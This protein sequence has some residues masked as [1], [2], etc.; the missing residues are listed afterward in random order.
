MKTPELTKIYLF[1]MAIFAFIPTVPFKDK[2]GG[3]NVRKR[4]ASSPFIRPA[5][6]AIGRLFFPSG[7]VSRMIS[8][9]LLSSIFA[10]IQIGFFKYF[11]PSLGHSWT[12]LLSLLFIGFLFFGTRWGR[13][14]QSW[15][16]RL[17]DQNNYD[18][19][20]ILKDASKAIITMLDLHELLNY[21]LYC[22]KTSLGVEK[23]CLFLKGSDGGYVRQ[24]TTRDDKPACCEAVLDKSVVEWLQWTGK[25]LVRKDLETTA[26]DEDF[27]GV[28]SYMKAAGVEVFMPLFFKGMLQG[29][30]AL[31]KKG[32]LDPY[33][34]SDKE[35]LEALAG[36]AAVAIENARLYEK[37]R[38]VQENLR[39]SEERFR[40]LIET[41]SDWVWEMNDR[42]V[43]TYVSPKISEILGYEVEE[44][45]GKTFFDFMPK[46]EA[47]RAADFFVS[48]TRHRK[49]F[50][51]FRN[52][53]LHKNGRIVII[54]T[55][56]APIFDKEGEF[57]GY[58][59]IDRDVTQRN[60]LEGQLR[61][62]QKMEAIGRLA[63]GVAH[64][65]NNINTAIVGYAG[66]LRLSME[67]N[68]QRSDAV[69]HILRAT[70]RAAKL[71]QRLLAFG[72]KNVLT[73][74]PLNLNDTLMSMEKLVTGIIPSDI[75]ILFRL[76]GADPVIHADA[77]EIERVIMNLVS[78]AR[79][80]MAKGGRLII[81][82]GI[83]TIDDEFITVH[84]YGKPGRYAVVSVTDTGSGIDPQTLKKIFEPFFTTKGAGKGTGFG[85]S[86]V[87]DI[88]KQ[89]E[90]YITVSSS[91]GEGTAFQVYLPTQA[92]GPAPEPRVE[93]AVTTGTILVAGN[94]DDDRRFIKAAL[95]TA[96]YAVIEAADGEEALEKFE[97][98]KAEIEAV[99]LDIIM[100]RKNGKETY[101]TIKGKKPGA[102][103][104]FTS[105][106]S[107]EILV[108]RRMLDSTMNF[109]IK[110]FSA[111]EL[112]TRIK[113]VRREYVM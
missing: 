46:E 92:G 112:L 67:K 80:A 85:L 40:S 28:S 102:K 51:L 29:V 71:T 78:N 62:A 97:A 53:W 1:F 27:S 12:I 90:G 83:G 109:I 37:A 61:Y 2:T 65:F 72:K 63:A 8:V 34:Q 105:S 17:V 91:P 43:Y 107:E 101:E 77:V 110:P 76:S 50:K 58:R 32:T 87:Y 98:G 95:E 11:E 42:G 22:I 49:P 82:T 55:S 54:E 74:C 45:L 100:P 88:V 20:T 47:R 81:E 3:A 33:V 41:T 21:L 5:L 103:V 13:N 4:A 89:H 104:L 84:G 18:Y 7:T 24:K 9:A 79:D 99:I 60:E 25:V 113:A 108:E 57:A 6:S 64:D 75:E 23:A 106:Y 68:D 59:G 10:V 66:I 39:E 35:L 70:E 93:E 16:H 96:G 19:Q 52:T 31:G 48:L 44:V 86:I 94:D 111:K 36:H 69:D 14:I 56:G 26:L 15:V 73:P 30:I 38:R